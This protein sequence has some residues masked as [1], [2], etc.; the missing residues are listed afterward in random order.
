MNRRVALDL[1][2]AA[3]LGVIALSLVGPRVKAKLDER[4]LC[5]AAPPPTWAIT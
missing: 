1:F 5:K 2:A 3:V 4:A